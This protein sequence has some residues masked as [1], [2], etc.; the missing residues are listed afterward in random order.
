MYSNELMSCEQP[1]FIQALR[2]KRLEFGLTDAIING[3]THLRNAYFMAL[4]LPLLPATD[5]EVGIN[6]IEQV[7]ENNSRFATFLQYIRS[8]WLRSK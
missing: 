7:S 6:I 8:Y 1:F 2:K 5:M 4:S 3:A